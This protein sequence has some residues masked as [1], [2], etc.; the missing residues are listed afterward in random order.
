VTARPQPWVAEVIVPDG[1]HQGERLVDV[2][3]TDP[4]WV[5]VRARRPRRTWPHQVRRAVRILERDL[6]ER[7]A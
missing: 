1:V 2:V 3:E 7:A 6:A 5:V 4:L